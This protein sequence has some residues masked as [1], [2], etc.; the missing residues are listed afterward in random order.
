ME[1]ALKEASDPSAYFAGRAETFHK[2]GRT[3]QALALLERALETAAPETKS[4]LAA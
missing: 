4:G 1:A 2:E 3:A